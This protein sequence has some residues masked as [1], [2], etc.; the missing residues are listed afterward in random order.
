MMM[1]VT[2]T[3]S[4]VLSQH[5][6]DGLIDSPQSP[7]EEGTAVIPILQMSKLRLREVM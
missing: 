7:Y 6:M 3:R 5:C 2:P 4:W 1:T